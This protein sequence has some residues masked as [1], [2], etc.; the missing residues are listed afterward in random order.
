MTQ[1]ESMPASSAL[2]QTASIRVGAREGADHGEDHA[3]LHSCHAWEDTLEVEVKPDR[4]VDLGQKVW[5][6][7]AD[8]RAEACDG[9]RANLVRLRH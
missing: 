7:V 5:G 3:E 8:G 9:D 4:V 6:N 1:M 2:S